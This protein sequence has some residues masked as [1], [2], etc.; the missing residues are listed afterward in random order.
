[1]EHLLSSSVFLEEPR[2]DDPLCLTILQ[3]PPGRPQRKRIDRYGVKHAIPPL[4]WGAHYMYCENY[5]SLGEVLTFLEYQPS[6][7]VIRG[8]PPQDKAYYSPNIE[9]LLEA[10]GQVEHSWSFAQPIYQDL[11]AARRLYKR[12][13]GEGDS[14]L[15]QRE[16]LNLQIQD[17]FDALYALG[18]LPRR[19]SVFREVPRRWVWL[20]IDQGLELPSSFQLSHQ[21]DH[22]AALRWIARQSLPKNFHEV[23][24]VGQWSSSAFMR[25]FKVK[26]HFAFLF[27]RPLSEAALKAWHGV[28]GVCHWPVKWDLATFRTVQPHFTAAPKFIHMPPPINER[29]FLVNGLLDL[30][31]L[32]EI[33]VMK[34]EV[35][36]RSLTGGRSLNRDKKGLKKDQKSSSEHKQDSASFTPSRSDQYDEIE[37][38]QAQALTL[39]SIEPHSQTI[40]LNPEVERVLG[41]QVERLSQS[42]EG[43]RNQDLYKAACVLGRYYGGGLIHI[44]D[45]TRAL[46]DGARRCGLLA[47]VGEAECLRQIHNGIRWGSKR[48]VKQDQLTA[49]LSLKDQSYQYLLSSRLE[50]AIKRAQEKPHCVPVLALTC[51]GGKTSA[52]ITL[53]AKD[54]AEG[55]TRIVLCRNHL[56]ADEFLSSLLKYA[57]ENGLNIKRRVK[58]LEGMHRHCRILKESGPA[59]AKRLQQALAYGRQALCGRGRSRCEYAKT[60]LGAKRPQALKRGVTIATHAMGPQLEIPEGAVIVI[61]ELPTPVK[62]MRVNLSDLSPL[63]QESE[64]LNLPLLD[65]FQT[66][67]DAHPAIIEAARATQMV[68]QQLA[69]SPNLADQD[70]G[71]TLDPEEALILFAEL[72]PAL[73]KL[74]ELELSPMPLPPPQNTRRGFW[75]QLPKKGVIETL[76]ELA[77]EVPD[78]VWPSAVSVHWRKDE[79]WLELREVYSLPQGALVCLDGTAHRTEYVWSYLAQSSPLLSTEDKEIRTDTVFENEPYKASSVSHLSPYVLN[80]RIR[81][82]SYESSELKSELDRDV[83]IW[84][85]AAVG[86]PPLF[87]R[88]VK[89]HSLRTSQ[90]IRRDEK[91]W[92][93]WRKRAMGTLKR[94]GFTIEKAARDAHLDDTQSIGILAAKHVADLFRCALG[95]DASPHFN[96]KQPIVSAL[97]GEIKSALGHRSLIIGHVGAHDIGSNLFHGVDLLAMLGS[98]KPDWG[99]TISDL[100]ALGVPEDECSEVYTHIVSARDVQALARARHLRRRGVALL[101]IGDMPPPV[102]HD[103]PDVRWSQE[104]AEHL[105]VN[106]ALQGSEEAAVTL[107]MSS[108]YIT[109]PMLREEL[110]MTRARAESVCKRLQRS[111]ELVEWTHQTSGRGRGSRAFGFAAHHPELREESP[112]SLKH[113][114]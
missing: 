8:C 27:E 35:Q 69:Q 14:T 80:R 12:L 55:K 45:L 23:S 22:H 44:T 85:I 34:L 57:E 59:Q 32:D 48:P 11:S 78:G 84:H 109:V 42:L 66:W 71:Q 96:L 39:S 105:K 97:I 4:V 102:G 77:R 108:G 104:E 93:H 41:L 25:G 106:E 9:S 1:M 60:C 10:M 3:A 47:K 36:G 19:K 37:E 82:E 68:L 13:E 53:M 107:L 51:G 61:D 30:V 103:L 76:L 74:Q 67:R 83:D 111:Y 54:A 21:A 40:E 2:A 49:A 94:I 81:T 100:R 90:L 114:K 28:R 6:L 31:P 89:T 38:S 72:I 33:A 24:F 65:S 46:I 62:G 43:Q 5:Q 50:R 16:K 113:L 101:Y 98:S 70:Y 92:I 99:S 15:K 75:P 52:L 91:A 26:A 7:I 95:Q 87:A 112:I 20:D 18:W 73:S 110:R 79:A 63:L 56:M 88:W 64:Q 17:Y 86:E 58:L 29:T